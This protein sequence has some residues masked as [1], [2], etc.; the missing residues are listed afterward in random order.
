MGTTLYT[1]TCTPDRSENKQTNKQTN[2]QNHPKESGSSNR[3][4]F[5]ET[6]DANAQL[7]KQSDEANNMGSPPRNRT[8]LDAQTRITIK[9]SKGVGHIKLSVIHRCSR[10]PT[11]YVQTIRRS[12]KHGIA[13]KE[14]LRSRRAD[15]NKRRDP[16][17][18]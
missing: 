3:Q 15:K 6:V 10:R 4:L 13:T 12:Q 8:A 16:N 1:Y 7:F 2:K 5:T 17:K 14:S 18:T 9:T 11:H